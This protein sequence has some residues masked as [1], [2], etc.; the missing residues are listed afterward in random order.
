[1]IGILLAGGTGSRLRPMTNSISKQLLPI[2]DKPMI[3]YP[4][5]LLMASG[6]REFYVIVNPNQLSL[7]SEL[8]LDGAQWG[9]SIKL[10]VQKNPNGI[11][12]AFHLTE[13]YIGGQDVTLILGDNIFYGSQIAKKISANFSNEG[14]LIY[15][16]QVKDTSQFGCFELSDKSITALSEKPI[17]GKSGFA[18]PGLYHFDSKVW[19]FASELKPSARGELEI[20]DLLKIYLESKSLHYSILDRGTAWLD[21]GNAETLFQAAQLIQVIQNRQGMII[22][23]PEEVAF[24][25]GW[26]DELNLKKHLYQYG[27][28]TYGQS[29]L[30]LL[31]GK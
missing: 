15:G 31:V 28:S 5:S 10:I 24:R 19:N 4:L 6:I 17:N 2:Y 25:C 16:Y 30:K 3:Y 23:S 29:L 1:M 12:E 14:A 21:T 26:I 9:I 18:I 13:K 8:L 20:I 11:P 7:F 27:E 22:G